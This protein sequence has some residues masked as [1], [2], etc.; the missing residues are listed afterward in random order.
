MA[1]RSIGHILCK[2]NM[3]TWFCCFVLY[4]DSLVKKKSDFN[5]LN[6]VEYN[7]SLQLRQGSLTWI[8]SL[9]LHI[10]ITSMDP[11]GHRRTVCFT[12]LENAYG[13]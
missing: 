10:L 4:P 9:D 12:I 3:T 6:N 2:V 13:S 7:S 5:K 8:F 11:E 1:S